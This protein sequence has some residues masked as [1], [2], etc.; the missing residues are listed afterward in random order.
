MIDCR[1]ERAK[2]VSKNI[3]KVNLNEEDVEA[4][5]LTYIQATSKTANDLA[6][7]CFDPSIQTYKY[8]A[9]LAIELLKLMLLQL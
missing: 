1:P 2:K 4:S 8:Y 7:N 3:S 6:D 5:M 9:I